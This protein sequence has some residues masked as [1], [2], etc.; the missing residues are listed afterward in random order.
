MSQILFVVVVETSGEEEFIANE[1]ERI[2]N[3][4]FG[5]S[6]K[7]NYSIN[8]GAEVKQMVS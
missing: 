6:W 4:T 8:G 3:N 7:G 2:L 1:M 5:S